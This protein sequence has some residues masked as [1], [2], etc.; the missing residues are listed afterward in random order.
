MAL[1]AE[2]QAPDAGLAPTVGRTTIS[3]GL[4]DQYCWLVCGSGELS[5]CFDSEGGQDVQVELRQFRYAIA[6]A[7]SRSFRRAAAE[8]KTSQS[9]ISRLVRDLED[10]VGVSLFERSA[11]GVRPTLA[12]SMFLE[13]IDEA[14]THVDTAMRHAQVSGTAQE[15]RLRVGLFS[16]LASQGGREL[17]AAF[18]ERHPGVLI[19]FHEGCP[20]AQLRQLS[21]RSLD[22]VLTV[23]DRQPHAFDSVLLWRE[24]VYAA[25]AQSHPLVARTIL[26]WAALRDQTHLIMGAPPGPEIL[27]YLVHKLAKPGFRPKV[28]RHD[29]GRENLMNLVGMNFGVVIA[30]EASVAVSYPQVAYRPISDEGLEFYGIWDPATDNPALR[31]FISLA[32]AIA[33]THDVARLQ[34]Q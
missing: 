34:S 8:L 21:Q 33:G 12:G 7:R 6:A 11:K 22:I 9:S 24:R 4:A 10:R 26:P 30:T 29:V 31:R 16:S 27:D 18:H 17:V 5:H 14:L 2:P 13:A 15:G 19:T 28:V 20:K 1:P 23:G 25:L 3:R 32:R